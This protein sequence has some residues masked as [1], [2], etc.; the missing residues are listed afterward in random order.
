MS[1][2]ILSVSP[3]FYRFL[4]ALWLKLGTRVHFQVGTR[5]RPRRIVSTNV[6]SNA[7]GNG[8]G[9]GRRRK[10]GSG[11]RSGRRT[12]KGRRRTS[13]G[14]EKGGTKRGRNRQDRATAVL[15]ARPRQI[16]LTPFVGHFA[17]SRPCD[18]EREVDRSRDRDHDRDPDREHVRDAKREEHRRKATQ[19]ASHGWFIPP[20][21]RTIIP[22]NLFPTIFCSCLLCSLFISFLT[23]CDYLKFKARFRFSFKARNLY[24]IIASIWTKIIVVKKI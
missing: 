23:K 19:V 1:T 22:Q 9:N 5:L 3:L 11:R 15:A 14:S 24:V 18:R 7:N 10:R 16:W 13:S 17:D 2:Q 4:S 21:A 12:G 6:I 20:P 8:N